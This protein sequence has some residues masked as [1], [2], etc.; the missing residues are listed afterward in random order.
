MWLQLIIMYIVRLLK[1]SR[2]ILTITHTA[3]I[4][5]TIK[6]PYK[7][8]AYTIQREK[9]RKLLSSMICRISAHTQEVRATIYT[10]DEYKKGLFHYGASYNNVNCVCMYAEYQRNIFD[11]MHTHART[12]TW[13]RHP[14]HPFCWQQSHNTHMLSHSP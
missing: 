8:Y 14:F 10:L 5:I 7:I 1:Q 4:F 9:Y 13:H 6:S 3:T 12:K 11:F 2:N